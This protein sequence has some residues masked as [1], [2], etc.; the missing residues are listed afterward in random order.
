[1]GIANRFS[2]MLEQPRLQSVLVPANVTWRNR[3]RLCAILCLRFRSSFQ[4]PSNQTGRRDGRQP[5]HQRS[6]PSRH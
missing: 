3:V 5:Y 4:P 6:T 2:R 1:M